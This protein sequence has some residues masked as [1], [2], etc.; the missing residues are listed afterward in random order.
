MTKKE[1]AQLQNNL[2]VVYTDGSCINNGLPTAIASWSYIVTDS[3]DNVLEA[4]TGKIVGPQNSNRAELTA[5]LK[6]LQY[7]RNQRFDKFI[8]RTDYEALVLFCKGSSHPKANHDLYKQ[9][10]Y[11][12]KLVQDRVI[13]EKVQ[14]H[15][16]HLSVANS[17]NGIV[18]KL[19]RKCNELF[20]GKSA[21]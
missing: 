11:L 1:L 7:I 17:M 9:I 3:N 19:A 13:V 8:I 4:S 20:S 2:Y 18:D 5:F 15:Q 16:S 14:G 10:D 21:V 6:A 12:Y